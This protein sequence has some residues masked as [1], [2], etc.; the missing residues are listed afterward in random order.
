[1]KSQILLYIIKGAIIASFFTLLI[2]GSGFIFPFVFPKTAAFQI[3][4]EIMFFVWILLAIER[5]EF[6]PAKTK[7]FWALA[8]FLAILIL[9]SLFGVDFY[10]SF[11]SNYERMTGIITLLHYF[12]YFLVLSSVL[13]TKKDWLLIF[14]SFIVSGILVA[15]VALL[16]KLNIQAFMLAGTGRLSSTLGNAAY[17]A[18][19]LLFI[20]FFVAFMFFQRPSKGVRIYYGIVFLFVFTILYWTETRGALLALVLA[21]ILFFLALVFWPKEAG[22]SETLLRFRRK[23][24]KI[25]LGILI[26]LVIFVG[27]VY[28][29]KNAA[30]VKNS[31]TLLRI[32][33]IS[34]NEPT[35][36]TRLLAWK[37]SLKGFADR[38]IL[39]WG[40]ENYNVVFNKYYDPHLYPIESWFD[41]AHNIVFDTLI[42]TGLAGFLSFFGIFAIIFWII[43]R[44]W[45]RKKID[46]LNA[47]LFAIL[48]LAYLAQ[49]FFVFDMLYS[50]LPLFTFFAFISW[51]G[52]SGKKAVISQKVI[53]SNIFLK[54]ILIIVFVFFVYSFNIKPGIVG[55]TGIEALKQLQTQNIA[56]SE[57]KFKEA[58]D[59]G[60][61]G[62]FEVRLQIFETAKNLMSAYQ[63]YQDKQSIKNFVDFALDEGDKTLSELPEDA[64]YHLLVGQVNLFASQI[65]PEKLNKAIEIF[66]ETLKESPDRQLT[67]YSLGQ[68]ELTAGRAEE[69]L[70][71]FKR[72]VEVNNDVAESYFD[73]AL[74]YFSVGDKQNGENIMA[75]INQKFGSLDPDQYQKLSAV[76]VNQKNYDQAI[77]YLLKAIQYAPTNADYYA[78]LAGLYKEV[79]QKDKA[80]EA[81]LKAGELNPSLQSGVDEFLKTL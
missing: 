52:T 33:S 36:Q 18:A 48:P 44:A 24:K 65:E 43:W 4:V 78:S 46:F 37:L 29:G 14:D 25:A 55:S 34:F 31:P 12:V 28:F 35:S 20:L 69:A 63:N 10:H 15:L 80:K 67:L 1:M 21:A 26:S 6:R 47:S 39:G 54:I 30:W 16:Q 41:R 64:R 32:T 81:A 74:V 51:I 23:I 50:Y 59:Y 53:K 8:L 71:S 22:Q 75:Q 9:A 79:G 77:V 3:L 61:F 17:L 68:A 27:A 76:F 60:T 45:R 62:R 57:Q 13:K 58:L 42:T 73:L 40:W 19:Y 66:Q 56:A 2:V 49:D 7:L 72:A 38:P 5:P 70:V 11:W